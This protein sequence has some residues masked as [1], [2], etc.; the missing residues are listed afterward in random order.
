MILL[1]LSL[2]WQ[3]GPVFLSYHGPI[4]L[5][6]VSHMPLLWTLLDFVFFL[7]A[8][9]TGLMPIGGFIFV[10]LSCVRGFDVFHLDL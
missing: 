2:A 1:C 4:F 5:L 8:Y 6:L 3:T 9:A 7:W 10:F